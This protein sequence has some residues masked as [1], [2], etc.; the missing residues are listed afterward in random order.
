MSEESN[1]PVALNIYEEALNEDTTWDLSSQ[2]LE[3]VPE[4]TNRY[5]SVS[6]E[7]FSTET[8]KINPFN[9]INSVSCSSFFIWTT[10]SYQ[11]SILSITEKL[12][13]TYLIALPIFIS[14]S[15]NSIFY[16]YRLSTYKTML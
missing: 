10:S 12:G 3:E 6:D 7:Y 2:G 14:R 11:V 13:T 15:S 5:L 1:T 8:E 4:L 9:N 16:Y